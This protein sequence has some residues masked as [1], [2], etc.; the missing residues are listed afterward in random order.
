MSQHS[1][2]SHRGGHKHGD[3]VL[4]VDSFPG[5]A[6]HENLTLITDSTSRRAENELRELLK[7]WNQDRIASSLV[8][9][10]CDWIFTPPRAS[11]RGGVWERLT[12]SVRQILR[13]I[14][15]SQVVTDEVFVATITE[16]EKIMNDQPLVKNSTDPNEYAVLTSQ[17]FLLSSTRKLSSSVEKC[18][19]SRLNRRWRQAQHL[20]DIFW[21]R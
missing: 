17:H 7:K 11:H 8:E 18:N 2:S 20:V 3:C 10:R 1:R 19:P 14:L 9:K 5:E 15:G 6:L 21:K 16:T 12:R 4:S 13:S